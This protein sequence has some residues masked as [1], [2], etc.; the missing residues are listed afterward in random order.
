MPEDRLKLNVRL[1]VALKI[2]R[3]RMYNNVPCGDVAWKYLDK[4]AKR[5]TGIKNEEMG[6]CKDNTINDKVKG[7]IDFSTETLTIKVVK[8]E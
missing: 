2:L 3:M 5:L 4:L 7:G 6:I 1:I 8:G